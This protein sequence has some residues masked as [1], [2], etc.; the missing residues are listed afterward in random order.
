MSEEAEKKKQHEPVKKGEIILRDHEYDGIQEY[1]QHLP[2]WWLFTFYI[3]VAFFVVYWLAFFTLGA[4][5]SNIDTIER[6][7]AVIDEARKEAMLAM[8]NDDGLWEM[9]RDEAI[10]AEGRKIYQTNCMACHGMNLGGKS[11]GP[12]Y[13]GEPL[14]DNEWKYGANPVAVYNL[15]HNGSPDL[16]KGMPPWG[17]MLG[18]QRVAQVVSFVLSH[19]EPGSGV[20]AKPEVETSPPPAAESGS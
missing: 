11:E 18:P 6:K 7:L 16:T 13:V 15:V 3:M 9:S 12:Q 17:P 14:N 1:D 4:M 10:V 5:P 19:H 2:N 8:L 20:D